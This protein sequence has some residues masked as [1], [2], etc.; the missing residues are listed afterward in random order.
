MKG[1]LSRAWY[2][3]ADDWVAAAGTGVQV[4]AAK[5]FFELQVCRGVRFAALHQAR[6]WA[7]II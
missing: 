6:L 1:V 4:A 5:T 2:S 3:G 7:R